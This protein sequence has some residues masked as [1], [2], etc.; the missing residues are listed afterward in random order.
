M[1]QSAR[2]HTARL[3]LPKYRTTAATEKPFRS[4][5]SRRHVQQPRNALDSHFAR[6]GKSG[7]M[8]RRRQ[9]ERLDDSR[10]RPHRLY[11]AE[12]HADRPLAPPG[13][14]TRPRP[15]PK[16]DTA[17]EE[18]LLSPGAVENIRAWLTEPRYAEYAP[19]VAEHMQAGRWKELDDV[20]WTIIPFGTGGRRGKCIRSAPTR[21]TIARSAKAPRGWPITSSEQLGRQTRLSCAIAYDT[22]HRSR[23]FAELCAEVMAAAGFKVYFLDGY[24]STPELSFTVRYQALQL[25]HHGHGQ[26]QPAQRQR[27]ES[28]L[29]DR[30]PTA[31]AA[32]S[33]A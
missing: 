24:R 6:A 13:T 10:M 17:A 26:P 28:L 11:R 23:H 4:V 30:R 8:G 31:A 18:K 33:R 14:S 20:F 16:L 2:W 32:R 22:R 19:L 21:S 15:D 7:T 27:G 25:R 12:R 5:F 1:V 29:V 3:V 9:L